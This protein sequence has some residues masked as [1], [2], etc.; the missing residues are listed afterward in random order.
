MTTELS[1]R[2][3]RP[4]FIDSPSGRLFA[5]YHGPSAAPVHTA[6]LY[7]PPFAEEMNRSRRMAALQARALASRGCGVL[8]LDLIGTGDS[9]GEFGAARLEAWLADIR[10]G[11]DWLQR[12]H[13]GVPV[14]WGLRLGALLACAVAADQPQRFS[15]LLLWQPVLDGKAMLRQFLRIRSA[16]TMTGGAAGETTGALR[17]QLASGDALEVAG[18]ELSSE[19]AAAL[20]RMRLND[21]ALGVGSRVDWLELG[22]E[23]SERLSPASQRIADAWAAAGVSVL[24]KT[25]RGDPFW[26]LQETT[27]APELLAATAVVIGR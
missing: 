10:A 27:L 14:L 9:A 4:M 11:A 24:A 25:V 16:A 2:G 1:G 19:L 17:A 12:G 20:D 6:V 3:P 21:L 18:Y 22:I 5:V 15:R 23:P 26:T 7:V 8:L 13:G